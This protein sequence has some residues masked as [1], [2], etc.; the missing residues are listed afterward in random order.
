MTHVGVAPFFCQR[1]RTFRCE[2]EYTKAKSID[3]M[4]IRLS[5]MNMNINLKG[6]IWCY[7]F[8]HNKIGLKSTS[9]R[10]PRELY[11][12]HRNIFHCVPKVSSTPLF[13]L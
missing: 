7:A 13:I 10:H 8:A 4:K 5:Y 1:W 6:N 9:M 12:A 3:V 11:N 2:Q